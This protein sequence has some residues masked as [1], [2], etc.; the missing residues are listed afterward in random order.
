MA[1]CRIRSEHEIRKIPPALVNAHQ[2]AHAHAESI[3][4]D[5]RA[6]IF[7]GEN[8]EKVRAFLL[9]KNVG[10]K[11]AQELIAALLEERAESIRADGVKK[12][13]LGGLFALAPVAYFLFYRF[14]GDMELKIFSGLVVL[15][16]VGV[17]RIVSGLRMILRPQ[18]VTGDL[19]N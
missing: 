5:A 14:A 7:W 19:S 12:L 1:G 13:W 3:V 15:G 6:K 8:A 18:T 9:S 2:V 17:T 16:V 10:D 11:E 4:T